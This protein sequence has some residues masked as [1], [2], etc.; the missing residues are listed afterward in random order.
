MDAFGGD[1][2]SADW[3]WGLPLIAMSVVIHVLALGFI[4]DRADRILKRL[5]NRPGFGPM[6]AFVMSVAVTLATLF[7]GLEAGLWGVAYR[8]LGAFSSGKSAM[9]YSLSA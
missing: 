5:S 3:A 6:F 9:L 4:T 7:H 1:T 2:W 8:T